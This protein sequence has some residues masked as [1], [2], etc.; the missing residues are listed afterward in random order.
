MV[1]RFTFN[2]N[3]EGSSP[4]VLRMARKTH[5]IGVRLGVTT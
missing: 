3:V 2:E 4:T 1:E 5:A